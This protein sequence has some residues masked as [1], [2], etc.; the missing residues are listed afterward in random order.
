MTCAVH[1]CAEPMMSSSA[2]TLS[3]LS[4]CVSVLGGSRW[5]T[6]S[7]DKSPPPWAEFIT[8]GGLCRLATPSLQPLAEPQESRSSSRPGTDG[9]ER[10]GCLSSVGTRPPPSLAPPPPPLVAFEICQTGR[11]DGVNAPPGLERHRVTQ[12]A[13]FNEIHSEPPRSEQSLPARSPPP[14]KRALG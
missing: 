6:C 9:A 10:S 3:D 7:T 12:L 13:T 11:G 14:P 8:P 5:D 1:V 2:Q 4:G